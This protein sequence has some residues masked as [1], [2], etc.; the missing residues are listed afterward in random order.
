MGDS[1]A[2]LWKIR[3]EPG[4]SCS[5]RKCFKKPQKGRAMSKVYG[6]EVESVP[7]GQSK[8]NWGDKLNDSIVV[9]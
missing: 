4:V 8:R 1:K 6:T 2:G 7:N 3:N 5:D 9:F